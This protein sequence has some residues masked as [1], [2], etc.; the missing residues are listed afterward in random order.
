M[1]YLHHQCDRRIQ[2]A[3]SE[4]DK[5]NDHV[6]D[7]RQPVKDTV[8]GDDGYHKKVDWT[9]AGLGADPFPV[10]NLF[11]GTTFWQES[12]K[13]RE[14]LNFVD[15]IENG[16]IITDKG[17]SLKIRCPFLKQLLTYL[18]SVFE[19]TQNLKLSLFNEIQHKFLSSVSRLVAKILIEIDYFKNESHI[20]QRLE[21][22]LHSDLSINEQYI[23]TMM[24]FFIQKL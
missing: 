2:P 11:W 24:T 23:K 22:F 8:S 3:A 12:V 21:N 18:I 17:R 10:R 6:P 13:G 4:S 7:R 20:L 5:G 14:S 9:Q 16:S 19:F 1:P 15:N